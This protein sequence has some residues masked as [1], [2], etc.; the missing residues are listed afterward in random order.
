MP[1]CGCLLF[2]KGRCLCGS[3]PS[4]N[5]HACKLFFLWKPELGRPSRNSS[6]KWALRPYRQQHWIF[7]LFLAYCLAVVCIW[8]DIPKPH[9]IPT[10]CVPCRMY[11]SL[12]NSERGHFHNTIQGLFL[13]C[14]FQVCEW[15]TTAYPNV[16]IFVVHEFSLD[17]LWQNSVEERRQRGRHQVTNGRLVPL[18]IYFNFKSSSHQAFT[19]HWWECK[20]I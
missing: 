9:N 10:I 20:W 18:K 19:R 2:E 3:S 4:Q 15:Y 7:T 16:F 5:P 12:F 8:A 13:P 6:T 11:S 14:D 1:V 17:G